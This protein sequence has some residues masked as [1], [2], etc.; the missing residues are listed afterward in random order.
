MRY[1][2]TLYSAAL[3]HRAPK[4]NQPPLWNSCGP[5]PPVFRNLLQL[6]LDFPAQMVFR[7]HIKV[8]DRTNVA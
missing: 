5:L 8:S 3:A 1:Q 6:S 7:L 4:L 2:E